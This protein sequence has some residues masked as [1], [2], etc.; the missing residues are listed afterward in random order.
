MILDE[1]KGVPEDCDILAIAEPL[2]DTEGDGVLAL[3]QIIIVRTEIPAHVEVRAY[4]PP[5][6]IGALSRDGDAVDDDVESRCIGARRM[7]VEGGRL[8]SLGHCEGDGDFRDELAVLG[9]A[10]E[11]LC[12]GSQ[13]I[14]RHLVLEPLPRSV[15]HHYE[16]DDD[17][18]RVP[19]HG[20]DVYVLLNK[21]ESQGIRPYRSS[22]SSSSRR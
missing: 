1:D 3:T 9:G 21:T 18:D 6:G 14:E 19:V 2:G 10:F 15:G 7:D 5:V 12:G 16:D 22:S 13:V 8:G 11:G 4:G 17:P 20:I